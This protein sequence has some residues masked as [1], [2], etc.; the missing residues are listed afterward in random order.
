[1]EV[2]KDEELW[3]IA[4]KRAAFKKH[5]VTYLIVNGFLWALWYITAG[6]HTDLDDLYLAW[7]IWSTLGWGI[8][9]AFNYFNAY[10]DLDSSTAVQKE[11]DKLRNERRG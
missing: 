3:K 10:H 8:G 6:R 2:I 11:Y 1:M 4:K 7:P 9:L 5:L